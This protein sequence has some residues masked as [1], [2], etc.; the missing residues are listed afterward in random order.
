MQAPQSRSHT[1][2]ASWLAAASGST[3]R[4]D[5][6][7]PGTSIQPLFPT[8]LTKIPHPALVTHCPY[9]RLTVHSHPVCKVDRG[10]PLPYGER[11]R[12]DCFRAGSW[13]DQASE[14][15]MQLRGARW[16]GA[17]CR[18]CWESPCSAPCTARCQ[19]QPAGVSQP[20]NH[21]RSLHCI[22]QP[23]MNEGSR[24]LPRHFMCSWRPAAEQQLASNT[25][26]EPP[27]RPAAVDDGLHCGRPGAAR[28]GGG[29]GCA[30][31]RQHRRQAALPLPLRQ[32]PALASPAQ[33]LGSA[34]MRGSFVACAVQ[35]QLDFQAAREQ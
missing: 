7:C 15:G 28:A 23:T 20:T 5:R 12:V 31:R 11:G 24:K 16:G 13:F 14:M 25:D 21:S 30:L 6:R 26:V 35:H 27:C 33:A 4:S 29:A 22:G 32:G 2:A 18:P 8:V 3:S 19:V 1:L 34:D 9:H 17:T 10:D